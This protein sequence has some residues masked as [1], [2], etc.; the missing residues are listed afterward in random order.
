[1]QQLQD[2]FIQLLAGRS[3]TALR[4]YMR[5]W[6]YPSCSD[7]EEAH[8]L[9]LVDWA[10]ETQSAL[11]RGEVDPLAVLAATERVFPATQKT[12]YPELS[13][14]WAEADAAWRKLRR[15]ALWRIWEEHRHIVP[16][17]S[18]PL[19]RAIWRMATL[20]RYPSPTI[21]TQVGD[22]GI[23]LQRDDQGDRWWLRLE[24]GEVTHPIFVKTGHL[25]PRALELK[26]ALHEAADGTKVLSVVVIHRENRHCPHITHCPT[27]VA[28][29][30][31]WR[32]DRWVF[33]PWRER[34]SD[35]YALLPQ[36]G[37]YVRLGDLVLD[38]TCIAPHDGNPQCGYEPIIP[39][40]LANVVW[41]GAEYIGTRHNTAWFRITDPENCIFEHPDH[42]A[43][44][45]VPQFPE[46]EKYVVVEQIAGQTQYLP[47]RVSVD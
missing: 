23:M 7:L 12:K 41:T 25:S 14:G 30:V 2:R 29:E 36:V 42:Y 34:T 24:P 35:F 21:T 32:G 19:R 10:N 3:V 8:N 22:I 45:I 46:H 4:Y 15:A 44:R 43:V 17:L 5:G 1:M 39:S 33:S 20:E 28:C 9:T 31:V 6:A 47:R 26:A 40:W 38:A 27:P 18:E 11:E 16:L 37:D 13:P